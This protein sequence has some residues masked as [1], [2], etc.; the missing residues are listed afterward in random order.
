MVEEDA[1]ARLGEA[2]VLWS[3]KVYR[4]QHSRRK[5]CGYLEISSNNLERVSDKVS[6]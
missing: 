5:M 3:K 6:G 1:V 4:F 2:A